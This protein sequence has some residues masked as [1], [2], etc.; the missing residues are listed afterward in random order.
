MGRAWYKRCKGAITDTGSIGSSSSSSR[1]RD[2]S[3]RD[4]N[5]DCATDA[6]LEVWP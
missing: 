5:Q 6:R 1:S 3:N 2:S 4:Y